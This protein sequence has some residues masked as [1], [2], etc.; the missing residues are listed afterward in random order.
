LLLIGHP[1]TP[2]APCRIILPFSPEPRF[3]PVST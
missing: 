2:G 3:Q 1:N